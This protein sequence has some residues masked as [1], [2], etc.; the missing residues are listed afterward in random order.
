MFSKV[1]AAQFRDRGLGV[2]MAH[3]DFINCLYVTC[4]VVKKY[5]YVSPVDLSNSLVEFKAHVMS[6][7]PI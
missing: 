1:K 2:P 4:H 7:F 6:P 5:I 3:V